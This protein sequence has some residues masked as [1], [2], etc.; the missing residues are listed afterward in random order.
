MRPSRMLLERP[1]ETKVLVRS[2]PT[3]LRNAAGAVIAAFD[4][5]SP[6]ASRKHR[7]VEEMTGRPYSSMAR[8]I[9]DGAAKVSRRPE[10]AF[11]RLRSSSRIIQRF[12]RSF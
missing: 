3:L 6:S 9:G 7:A 2:Y 10:V 8:S 5:L 4:V 11:N 1:D 12:R